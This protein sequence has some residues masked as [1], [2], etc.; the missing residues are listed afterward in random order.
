M[1]KDVNYINGIIAMK[2]K[3]LLGDKL[4]RMCELSPEEAL[5]LLSESGFGGG[6]EGDDVRSFEKLIARE[7]ENLDEFIRYCSPTKGEAAYLLS[8][9]D[10]H[11]AKAIAKGFLLGEDASAMLAPEGLYSLSLLK[12]AIEGGEG[13]EKLPPELADCVKKVRLWK[14]E[15]TFRGEEVGFLFESALFSYLSRE[16]KHNRDLKKMLSLRADRTN[17]LTAF[18]SSDEAQAEKRYLAGGTLKKEELSV[19]FS[20]DEDKILS[21]FARSEA[22]GFVK[23]CLA[24]KKEK[25]PFT[26]GEKLLAC[27]ETEEYG[28]KVYELKNRQPFL[29]YVFRRRAE[30]ADVRVV[31]VCLLSGMK[32]QDIKKRLRT[33]RGSGS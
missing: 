11:N 25:K 33:V 19:L 7:E 4:S 5:K 14:E 24:A 29:Y 30:N 26:E 6:E 31:F 16:V 15:E 8:P 21:A 22:L 12:K 13:W 28:K 9:R 1:A 32:E 17:I 23:A 3:K 2:E 18:R 27:S 20:G 10:F